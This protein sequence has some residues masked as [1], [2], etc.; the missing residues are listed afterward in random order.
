MDD[1]DVEAHHNV[2]PT[3][4]VLEVLAVVGLF[5]LAIGCF[6][7]SLTGHGACEDCWR[8]AT[9]FWKKLTGRPTGEDEDDSSFIGHAQLLPRGD[10]DEAP[11]EDRGEVVRPLSHVF[12]NLNDLIFFGGSDDDDDGDGETAGV[13][14]ATDDQP[15][16]LIPT[17]MEKIFPDL[18]GNDAEPSE[19]NGG[20]GSELREPLL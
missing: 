19:G 2:H 10:N 20:R 11:N 16:L 18:L 15:D 17:S 8:A 5:G 4:I 9:R 13:L 6:G 7:Y 12:Q 3:R 1:V 14:A